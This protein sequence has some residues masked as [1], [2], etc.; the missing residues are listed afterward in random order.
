MPDDEIV[1]VLWLQPGCTASKLDDHTILTAAHCVNRSTFWNHEETDE[2]APEFRPGNTLRVTERRRAGLFVLGEWTSFTV[3]RTIK[4]PSYLA[5]AFTLNVVDLALVVVREDLF[6]QLPSVVV[7]SQTVGAGT[8]VMLYGYGCTRQN[9]IIPQ[10]PRLRRGATTIDASRY[11][12]YYSTAIGGLAGVAMVD[13]DICDGD[14]GGPLQLPSSD[15]RFH[16]IGVN[17]SIATSW[18]GSVTGNF[19]TALNASTVAWIG[20]QDRSVHP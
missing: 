18:V 16:V 11:D 14:S 8:A 3:E 7:S 1:P 2:L 9:R 4:H 13:A 5:G 12:S 6:L 20:A 17:S 19:H 15:G 10:A